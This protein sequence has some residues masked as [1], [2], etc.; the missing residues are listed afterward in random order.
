M[1]TSL[2]YLDSNARRMLAEARRIEMEQVA[3]RFDAIA[4][5]K[6]ALAALYE[7]EG[8][9]PG[10]REAVYRATMARACAEGIR[11]GISKGGN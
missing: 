3:E 5:Q 7:R 8:N 1:S 9:E 2:G 4:E 6:E 11:K 10:R